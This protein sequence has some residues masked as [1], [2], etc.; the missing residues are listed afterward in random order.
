MFAALKQVFKTAE[1][2]VKVGGSD[3]ELA[4]LASNDVMKVL[5]ME[6]DNMLVESVRES[7]G[8]AKMSSAEVDKH[9]SN[10]IKRKQAAIT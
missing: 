8:N 3:V 4:L 7:T 1:T 6:T 5:V 9:V 10:I 2:L